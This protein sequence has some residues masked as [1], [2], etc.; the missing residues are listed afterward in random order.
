MHRVFKSVVNPVVPLKNQSRD[1]RLA[2]TIGC[3]FY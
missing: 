3:G 2:M 1:S